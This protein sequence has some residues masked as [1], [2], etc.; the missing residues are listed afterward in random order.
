MWCYFDGEKKKKRKENN[1]YL[2]KNSKFEVWMI[3][4]WD[5]KIKLFLEKNLFRYIRSIVYKGNIIESVTYRIMPWWLK[6]KSRIL[7]NCKIF[8][9]LPMKFCWMTIWLLLYCSTC[10]II[11]TCGKYVYNWDEDVLMDVWPYKRRQTLKQGYM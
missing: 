4:S 7:C 8:L 3:S 2:M 9:M 5:L 11:L 1:A 10:W 6:W